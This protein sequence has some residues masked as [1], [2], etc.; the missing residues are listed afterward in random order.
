MT[1]RAK[2]PPRIRAITSGRSG[3]SSKCSRAVWPTSVKPSSTGIRWMALFSRTSRFTTASPGE[4]APRWKKRWLS[5]WFLKITDYA[6]RLLDDLDGLVGWPEHVKQQQRNWLGRS[7]GA[8]IDFKL[9]TTGETLSVFTT[10]PDTVYGVTFMVCA[11][12]HPLIDQLLEGNPRADSIRE[13]V[14][15]MQAQSAAERMSEE[16]EKTGIETGH[17][18]INPVNGDRVPLLVADYALME[19]GTGIVMGVPAHDQ[20]DF[21]FRQES[22]ASP[23]RWSS[24]IAR[25]GS[26]ATR[27]R[28]HT[29]KT[30]S[31]RIPVPSTGS[32]TAKRIRR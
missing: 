23:S 4:A 7:E 3:F 28:R 29:S 21:L 30:A 27:W 2:F 18:I 6:Q 8:R 25:A 9:E 1:G 15:V 32:R 19:Y 5:Q 22:T 16:S 12:E 17:F 31:W 14:D 24:S 13:A 10:R 20:R 26:M 11:P